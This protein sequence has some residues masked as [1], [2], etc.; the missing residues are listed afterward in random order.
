M[1]EK[2]PSLVMNPG[3]DVAES[4]R[5]MMGDTGD[6]QESMGGFRIKIYHVRA[7]PWGEVFKALLYR[8]FKVYVTRHKAELYI[9]AAP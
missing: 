1:A 8:D 7:F 9:E 2:N 3:V 6:L 5:Y 4:L